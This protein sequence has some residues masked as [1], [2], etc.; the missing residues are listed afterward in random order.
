MRGLC[1]GLAV[2]AVALA[3][4]ALAIMADGLAQGTPQPSRDPAYPPGLDPGGV[5]VAVFADA[6]DYTD[7]KM[8]VRLARDGE[9]D[10]IGWDFTDN[11]ARPFGETDPRLRQFLALSSAP[12]VIVARAAANDPARAARLTSFAVRTPARIILTWD[13][14]PDRPDWALFLEG[15]RRF[16]DR[17]FVIPCSDKAVAFKDARMLANLVV[18]SAGG[19]GCDLALI[20]DAKLPGSPHDIAASYAAALG[21]DTLS[22]RPNATAADLKQQLMKQCGTGCRVGVAQPR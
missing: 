2:A 16:P 12:R 3:A 20:D 21:A 10:V 5:P 14:G 4:G 13:T 18:A 19:P 22:A 9:G 15:V 8:V 17:L 7:P 11:D 1:R 6:V